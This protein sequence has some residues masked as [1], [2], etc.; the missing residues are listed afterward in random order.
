MTSKVW[1]VMNDLE[2][3]TSKIVSARE[4]I[5]TAADAIQKNDSDK[6][7]T[8]AMAAYE[9]LGYYLEEFDEKFKLAWNETVKK[10]K[11]ESHWEE[12]YLQLHNRFKRFARYTDQELDEMCDSKEKEEDDGMRPWGHSDMEYLIANKKQPQYQYTAT[13]E[14]WDLY[15]EVMKEREY[16]EPTQAPLS[17]DR[18]D[19]SPECK[20]AWN[21]FWEENYY[22]EEHQQ[23]TEKELN[24]MCDKAEL[25][26][27]LEEIRKAGGYEWTPLPVKT[28]E[29]P[30]NSESHSK[31]YYD[32]TRNDPNRLNPFSGKVYESPDGGKTVYARNPGETK[33][34]LVKQETPKKKWV[35]P[36]E[37]CKDVDTDKTDYFITF[38]NDLLE[39]AKLKEGDEVNWVD[40][41]DGSFKIVKVLQPLGPDEC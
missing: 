5:D 1:E 41:G 17:C 28:E 6:A 18:N 10:Q 12:S 37:E 7:E 33:R 35:L 3:V 40:N 16:Y 25:D 36:V 26:A 8:L 20:G 14:K 11:S 38:P 4:I 15:D 29:S 19:P 39:A 32:Y 30:V 13:G 34:E 24:A 23:Y 9:F 27:Q 22:P 2:M 21:S 31:Y